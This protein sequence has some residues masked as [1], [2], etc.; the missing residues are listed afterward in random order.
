MIIMNTSFK[1]LLLVSFFLLSLSA[2]QDFDSLEQ[3]PNTASEDK[4]VP[5]S[6]LLSKILYDMY[7]GPGVLDARPGFVFEGPWGDIH[8]WNQYIVSNNIYYGGKNN[9]NWTATTTPYVTITNIKKMEEQ[10]AKLLGQNTNAYSALGKFLKAYHFIWLTQRTGDIP[11]KEAALG[12]ANLTPEFDSQKDVYMQS[13]QLLNEANDELATIIP[14]LTTATTI[15]DDIYFN[16]DLK[17]WQKA[18]NT[19]TLRVLISLSKRAD[20]TPELNIKQRFADMINNPSSYPLMSG[21]G[22]N[23]K[24]VYNTANSYPRQ[25]TNGNNNYQ[26]IGSTYLKLTA[27]SQDP[28]TFIVATPAPAELAKGKTVDDFTAYVGSDISDGIDLLLNNSTA[29]KYSFTNF[30]RYYSSSTGPEPYVILGYAEMNFNIAEGIVRGWAPGADAS[31]YYNR[32]VKASLDFYGLKEEDVLKVGDLSGKQLGTVTVKIS[33]F[34]A[35]ANVVFKGEN[36]DGLEQILNQKYIAFFQNSGLEAFY[37]QRR[38]GFPS[39]FIKTGAGLNAQEKLPLRWQYPVDE[40][41]YNT[42]H[43]NEAIQRQFDGTDDVYAKMWL[44]E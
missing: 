2:C 5:P 19:F 20:D 11:M 13:L 7:Q 33:D 25:P 4:P 8:R 26:N 3:N 42:A 27:A 44:L 34:L 21:N 24:F 14:T 43:V 15:S 17:L 1:K 16:N 41:T 37:N 28:R 30:L 10:A 9:Y 29:G 40:V 31:L 39:T 6:Y 23:L 18:I 36:A 12:L 32:G 35:N 22:D 38:T